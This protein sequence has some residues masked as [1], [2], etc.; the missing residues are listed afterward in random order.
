MGQRQKA[1]LD[2][3]RR[4]AA[5]RMGISAEGAPADEGG[6]AI[7]AAPAVAPNASARPPNAS[8]RR[9]PLTKGIQKG[10][11]G[12]AAM[13]SPKTVGNKSLH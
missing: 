5:E 2:E 10:I 8:S 7:G 11:A 13:L 12:A 4:L 1:K 6:G 9:Q 3:A